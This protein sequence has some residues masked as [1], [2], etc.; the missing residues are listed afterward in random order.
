MAAVCYGRDDLSA[1]FYADSVRLGQGMG[2]FGVSP[3]SDLA[4]RWR[5]EPD[6][7]WKKA[8]SYTAW[9][10]FNWNWCVKF[11]QVSRQKAMTRCDRK[12]M[13]ELR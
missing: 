11:L 5:V 6:A 9:G 1:K 4:E 10:V 12:L 7:K 2:L 13:S 8:G 3:E